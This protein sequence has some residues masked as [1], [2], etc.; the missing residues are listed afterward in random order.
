MILVPVEA[1]CIEGSDVFVYKYDEKTSTAVRKDIEIGISDDK[2]YSVISG[3]SETDVLIKNTTG[4]EDGVK[5]KV[6]R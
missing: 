6:T 1:V 3:V 5:V 4:L 2:N